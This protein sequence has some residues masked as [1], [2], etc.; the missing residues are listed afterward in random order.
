M[1]YRYFVDFRHGIAVFANFSY[2]IA[3]LGTP[4]IVPLIKR[5]LG[6]T[7]YYHDVCLLSYFDDF[8]S[9]EQYRIENCGKQY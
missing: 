9:F 5:Y 6:S 7:L 1:R 4:Q 8:G 3:V 2:G